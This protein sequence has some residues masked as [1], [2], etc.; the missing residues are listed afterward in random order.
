[1]LTHIIVFKLALTKRIRRDQLSLA[2]NICQSERE[3]EKKKKMIEIGGKT[4]R[5]TG[6]LDQQAEIERKNLVK[7]MS[8]P[9]SKARYS[10]SQ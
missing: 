6:N 1:M 5:K 10:F 8:K 9:L 3:C 7:S 2:L 4:Y